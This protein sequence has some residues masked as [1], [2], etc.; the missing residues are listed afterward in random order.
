MDSITRLVQVL[1]FQAQRKEGLRVDLP[2][3]H[4]STRINAVSF[5]KLERLVSELDMT[6]SALA[7]ELLETA[8]DA[9]Y[10][11]AFAVEDEMVEGGRSCI[12]PS[13][14]KVIEYLRGKDEAAEGVEV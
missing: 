1:K 12:V 11:E 8:I 9:A 13:P 5:Y 3:R 6:R 4:V 14:E 7:A 2:P 10:F